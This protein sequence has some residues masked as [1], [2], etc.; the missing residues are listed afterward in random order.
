MCNAHVKHLFA[1]TLLFSNAFFAHAEALISPDSVAV[2]SADA[3]V[4]LAIE[5]RMD[6]RCVIAPARTDFGFEGSYLNFVLNGAINN[7]I[8]YNLR[9]RIARDN[10]T[11]REFMNSVDW[12]YLTYAPDA[13]YSFSAGK[14]VVMIGTYEYDY[15]PIDI[16]YASD[17]WNHI[18]CYQLGVSA[19]RH[20]GAAQTLS[21]QV[22]NS[23]F[24]KRE[25]D[26]VMAFNLM[27]RGQYAPWLQT[28][29]SANMIGVR[30]GQY[31]NYVALGHRFVCHN[32]SFE[33]D[34]I[35][36]YGAHHTPVFAD[37][38]LTGKFDIDLGPKWRIFVKGGYDQNRSQ[39][40]DCAAPIDL[41]VLPG[42]ER[43]FYGAGIEWRPLSLMGNPLRL[44]AFW[45][46][47]TQH[48]QSTQTVAIGL[49]WTM[50]VLN[51][52]H[53]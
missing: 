30:R 49:R 15:A 19:S 48:G 45:D 42:V 5:A 37:F 52:T 47:E 53:K 18:P 7:H 38:T 10:G 27:W 20:W 46:G 25:H 24:S 29:Y 32:L 17:F 12:V 13:R 40:P 43:G 31:I 41:C 14:Q 35:N 3:M 8:S 4:H 2:T 1:V 51:L 34:Y 16:Y 33:L 39:A 26:T 28:I 9:Y 50:D 23:P 11:P 22:T 44:H 6:G 36:R 21:L